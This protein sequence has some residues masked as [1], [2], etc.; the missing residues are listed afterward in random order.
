MDLSTST[1]NH[2]FASF[3]SKTHSICPL[4]N[5]LAYSSSRSPLARL[6]SIASPCHFFLR[7]QRS[8]TLSSPIQSSISRLLLEN[9]PRVITQAKRLLFSCIFPTFLPLSLVP[10]HQDP[11]LDTLMVN[12]PTSLIRPIS[13]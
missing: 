2:S 13:S 1:N 6:I 7:A 4:F 9:D 10:A 8:W 12:Y 5:L 11:N 3:G